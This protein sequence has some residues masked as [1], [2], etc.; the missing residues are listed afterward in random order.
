MVKIPL[1][2]RVLIVCEKGSGECCETNERMTKEKRNEV[3]RT[4]RRGWRGSS[5]VG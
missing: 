2:A 1:L 5:S 3:E 4:G